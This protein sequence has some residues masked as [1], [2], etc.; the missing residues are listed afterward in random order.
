MSENNLE[1]G[2][3]VTAPRTHGFEFRG[4]GTEYFKIWIVNLCLSILTL[5]IYS[6]WATVR[7]RRYLYG[8][9]YLMDSAFD[10]HASG[11][12]ILRG[13]LFAVALFGLYVALG[14]WA[15]LWQGVLVLV[16]LPF[17]PWVIVQARRFNT[18]QT[19]WRGVRFGFERAYWP[20]AREFLLWP[21]LIPFTLG[22][23]FPYIYFRQHRFF[24]DN[25]RFGQD[26]F[27]LE[28]TPGW[29]YG[30]ILGVGAASAL[31][32]IVAALAGFMAL[33]LAFPGGSEGTANA[34]A[35]VTFALG[36]AVVVYGVM[37]V[38]G[39]VLRTLLLNHV[40]SQVRIRGGQFGLA[41]GIVP[42]VWIALSNV[43]LI[44]A[45]LGLATPW[46][47]VRMLRYRLSCLSC[48]VSHADVAAIEAAAERESAAVGDEVAGAFDLDVGIA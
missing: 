37:L 3:D 26:K 48:I 9:S 41:L 2:H 16:L 25:S 46:A 42:M 33:G 34:G 35:A 8:S 31:V 30:A 22:L 6:A 19:S 39:I 36:F 17:L 1:L 45:T 29:F 12:Q 15:P 47:K 21:L 27:R 7:N 14:Q 24:V 44:V 28:A 13:R 40:W 23:I 20:A 32:A 4:N 18:T 43:V 38:G 5:G 11:S 10:F